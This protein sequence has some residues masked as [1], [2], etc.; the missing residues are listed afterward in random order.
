MFI[1]LYLKVKYNIIKL[2][3][4]LLFHILFNT[5][6]F[7]LTQSNIYNKII[8]KWKNMILL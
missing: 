2:I 8:Q 3:Q 5:I 7:N 6:K 4:K 1:V